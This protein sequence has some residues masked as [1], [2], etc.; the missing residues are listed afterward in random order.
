MEHEKEIAIYHTSL[1]TY[2]WARF[3]DNPFLFPVLAVPAC[4]AMVQVT[5]YG[6]QHWGW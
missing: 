5:S 4:M 6:I 1:W 2:L 3:G